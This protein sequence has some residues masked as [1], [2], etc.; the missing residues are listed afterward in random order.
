MFS[1]QKRR[2]EKEERGRERGNHYVWGKNSSLCTLEGMTIPLTGAFITL[3]SGELVYWE[4]YMI[5][6]IV[7]HDG[8]ADCLMPFGITTMKLRTQGNAR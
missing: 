7:P 6:L 2:G 3:S 5:S 1:S 8:D 4:V